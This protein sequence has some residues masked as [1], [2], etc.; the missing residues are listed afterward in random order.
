MSGE[1]VDRGQ[2]HMN[3]MLRLKNLTA[4]AIL[5]VLAA[6]ILGYLVL[7]HVATEFGLD[8]LLD[9]LLNGLLIG[10]FIGAIVY[11]I[12]MAFARSHTESRHQA[13]QA[14]HEATWAHTAATLTDPVARTA[15]GLLRHP[16]H[17]ASLWH[18]HKI[19]DTPAPGIVPTY[20]TLRITDNHPGVEETPS[21]ARI[22]LAMPP[23]YRDPAPYIR[24][25]PELAADIGADEI[26]YVGLDDANTTIILD[27]ITRNPLDEPVWQDWLAQFTPRLH[28][29]LGKLAE[30]RLARRMWVNLGL[31]RD[32][33]PRTGE[34]AVH[35]QLQPGQH[36]GL[37]DIGVRRVPVGAL[38]RLSIPDGWSAKD[39]DT[40]LPHLA[41][42]LNVPEVRV[43]ATDGNTITLALRVLDPIAEIIWSPL[44]SVQDVI[45]PDGST[46]T[47]Y[48][49]TVRP[50]ALSCHDDIL[51]GYNEHGGPQTLNLAKDGHLVLGG[52]TRTGKSITLNNII[53]PAMLM[54]DVKVLLIDPNGAATPPWYRVLHRVC[55]DNDGDAAAAVLQEVLDEIGRRKPLFHHLKTDKITQFSEKLP[56]W[57]VAVDE[58]ANFRKHTLFGTLL[59]NVAAQALKYG[60]VLIL[61]SQKI[62]EDNIP[63]SVRTNLFNRLTHRVNDPADYRMLFAT[64]P[65]FADEA[66]DRAMAQGVAIASLVSHPTPIRMRSLYLPPAAC[67]A[68]GAAV[69]AVRGAERDHPYAD[70]PIDPEEIRIHKPNDK[71]INPPP[72]PHA[73]KN[74]RS[75]AYEKNDENVLPFRRHPP[76][77]VK[78][79]L[80]VMLCKA[81][82]CTRPITQKTGP[83]RRR[84]TCSQKCRDNLSK[85]RARGE[86][87]D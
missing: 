68:L 28:T 36:D 69:L 83:G 34:P 14:A 85:A 81:P 59:A 26:D 30:P 8:D 49:P 13:A 77:G 71:H 87:I 25:L 31:G 64:A 19:G 32:H 73:D 6:V 38:V 15:A 57:L 56:L 84:E 37:P 74:P 27:I 78:E 35:P 82:G 2:H 52:G 47:T 48:L 1:A 46:T 66:Q 63:T 76:M 29:G 10:L 24:A 16:Q 44:I 33:N 55:E 72:P 23:G 43:H 62:S 86:I 9:D 53:A 67:F 58:A 20:P 75:G 61:S 3:R 79:S 70:T 12:V 7:E 42:A 80:G 41:T 45:G 11:V 40:K 39:F 18:Q 51:L 65:Q 54:R 60:I 17:A 5:C 22:R 21:G 4:A 50:G